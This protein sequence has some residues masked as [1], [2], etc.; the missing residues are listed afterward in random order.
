MELFLLFICHYCKNLYRPEAHEFTE[1]VKYFL[2]MGVFYVAGV[3]IYILR[4]P[5]RFYSGKFDYIG[6]S[7]NIWHCMIICAAVFHYL[8][9]I[10]SYGKRTTLKCR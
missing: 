2:L 4:V 10:E 9:S 1:A 3:F 5:E 7:H 8:G 6:H